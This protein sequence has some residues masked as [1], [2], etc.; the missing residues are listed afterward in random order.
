[1]ADIIAPAV[2]EAV[3]SSREEA[4]EQVTVEIQKLSKG[5]DL[6]QRVLV[7]QFQESS[8]NKMMSKYND[9][10]K[11]AQ[12]ARDTARSRNLTLEEAY[13]IEKGKEVS[14]EVSGRDVTTERPTHSFLQG[15][16]P[17]SAR[18]SSTGP[19]DETRD[20]RGERTL[21]RRGGKSAFRD[22]LAG[23][24]KNAGVGE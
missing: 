9:Y 17:D 8:H 3:K 14:E 7:N 11:Y 21:A 10:E 4:T 5:L 19:A 22:L 23:G 24:M 13:H 16:R 1:M 15:R 12:K 6:T 2:E 18:T 20:G